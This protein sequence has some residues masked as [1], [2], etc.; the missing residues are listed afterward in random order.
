[1]VDTGPV[2]LVAVLADDQLLS[3]LAAGRPV[4]PGKVST[5]LAAW[6]DDCRRATDDPRTWRPESVLATMRAGVA[7]YLENPC[8]ETPAPR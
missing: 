2:D 6:R 1:M 7:N 5:L 8:P 4:A 3:A